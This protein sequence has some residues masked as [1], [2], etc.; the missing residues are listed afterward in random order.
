[1]RQNDIII[2]NLLSP[3]LGHRDRPGIICGF[4]GS[5]PDFARKFFRA[6]Q[7]SSDPT[8][9]AD[10]SSSRDPIPQIHP[11]DPPP[12]RSRPPYRCSRTDI[13]LMSGCWD[14]RYC[15][16]RRYDDSGSR[17]T[18]AE[19]GSF[20]IVGTYV[21]TSIRNLCLYRTY[22]LYVKPHMNSF[23]KTIYFWYML[24]N[25]YTILFLKPHIFNIYGNI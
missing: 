10:Y 23:T 6:T 19:G 25:V 21:M 8:T 22:D 12:K 17:Q 20:A 2:K 5:A 3:P 9:T 18:A 11:G 24:L 1:M 4:L 7:R 15:W 16:G 13:L 14:T